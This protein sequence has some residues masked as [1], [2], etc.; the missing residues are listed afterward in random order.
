VQGKLPDIVFADNYFSVAPAAFRISTISAIRRVAGK[1]EGLATLWR[2]GKRPANFDHA[3]MVQSTAFHH[4]P[5]APVG[6]VLGLQLQ[7]HPEHPL[8]LSITSVSSAFCNPSSRF[9]KSALAI[10]QRFLCYRKA[11]AISEF[12]DYLSPPFAATHR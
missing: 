7:G 9:S 5:C 12:A 4:R 6:G 2:Q 10:Y 3:T 11:A 1:L 8:D